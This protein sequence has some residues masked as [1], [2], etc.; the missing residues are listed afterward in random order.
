MAD[1]L[2]MKGMSLSDSQH[3]PNGA[4]NGYHHAQQERSAYIPPH[5]RSSGRG[6]SGPGEF[7]DDAP[8]PMNG[9]ASFA[10]PQRG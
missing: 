10:G 5:A 4:P 2:N 7:E 6:P 3:A 1:Q 8:P 9:G